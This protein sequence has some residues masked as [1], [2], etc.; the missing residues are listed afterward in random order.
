MNT[1]LSKEQIVLPSA[2][3]KK[4]DL[5]FDGASTT[6]HQFIANTE[7]K[8]WDVISKIKIIGDYRKINKIMTRKEGEEGRR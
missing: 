6:N 3:K 1:I 2:S 5:E 4:S 7:D 8:K